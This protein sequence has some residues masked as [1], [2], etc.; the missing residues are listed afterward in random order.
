[1]WTFPW[2]NVSLSVF[3]AGLHRFIG[4]QW[5]MQNILKDS[6]ESS[7]DEFFDARGQCKI[8]TLSILLPDLL[9]V[10][11]LILEWTNNIV[12]TRLRYDFWTGPSLSEMGEVLV[13]VN[14]Q[15][16]T[17]SDMRTVWS[18]FCCIFHFRP[19]WSRT[20]F[21]YLLQLWYIINLKM[22]IIIGYSS[23][24]RLKWMLNHQ[25]IYM[26]LTMLTTVF[27]TSGKKFLFMFW[28]AHIVWLLW[29]ILTIV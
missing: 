19:A 10:S 14:K 1:M 5:H 12:L 11:K 6:V 25:Y 27:L 17:A 4:D 26:S 15:P 2:V 3:P 21:N 23:I 24:F 22:L 7:D 16:W 8:F 13:C 28:E 20:A 9:Q 29:T 18:I